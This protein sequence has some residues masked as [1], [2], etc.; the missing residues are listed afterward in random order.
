MFCPTCGVAVEG[1]PRF[2]PRCGAALSSAAASPSAAIAPPVTTPPAPAAPW[3]PPSAPPAAAPPSWSPPSAYAGPRP[4]PSPAYWPPP[5]HGPPAAPMTVAPATPT[6]MT[7]GGVV[8]VLLAVIAANLAFFLPGEEAEHSHPVLAHPLEDLPVG[9]L[10][11]RHGAAELRGE[12]GG[13]VRHRERVPRELHG[14][15][16]RLRGDLDR[17]RDDLPDVPHGDDLLS[18]GRG[19]R[20]GEDPRLELRE[21]PRAP[22][23][24]HERHGSRDRVPQARA[25]EVPLHPRLRLEVRDPR[26]SVRGGDGG[27]HD[28]GRV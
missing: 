19:H 13:D 12:T 22:V 24:L 16:R 25:L 17:A 1:T 20:L 18:G 27:H 11:V 10:D 7:I 6:M 9:L 5:A 14:L 2:C 4:S 28:V 21:H 23:H 15:P 8:F 26:P 3:P